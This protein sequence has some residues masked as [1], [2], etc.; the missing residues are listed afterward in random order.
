MMEVHKVRQLSVSDY[1]KTCELMF[2]HAPAPPLYSSNT[3]RDHDRLPPCLRTGSRWRYQYYCSSW[4][5]VRAHKTQLH[6]AESHA[7]L[8]TVYIICVFS[9]SIQQYL[10]L[11][12]ITIDV[13]SIENKRIALA[14]VCTTRRTRAGAR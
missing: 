12:S 14:V 2:L 6:R 11:F 8:H 4:H 13:K 5:R 1:Y 7:R 9:S 10:G 3:C